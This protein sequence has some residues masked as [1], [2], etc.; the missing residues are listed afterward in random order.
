MT[1]KVLGAPAAAL[2]ILA[3]ASVAAAQQP[4]NNAM[5]MSGP[6]QQACDKDVKTLCP[7]VQPGGGRVIACLREN[8]AQV[9]PKCKE[10]LKTAK[11]EHG[12]KKAPQ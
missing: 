8:S 6:V 5:M 11:T 1:V 2:M 3:G 7:T 12:A 10:A 9:S 4:P